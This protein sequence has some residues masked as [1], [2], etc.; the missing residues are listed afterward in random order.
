MKKIAMLILCFVSLFALVACNDSSS[1]SGYKDTIETPNDLPPLADLEYVQYP[2]KPSG[3][4]AGQGSGMP[5][6]GEATTTSEHYKINQA[7]GKI[8][9]TFNEVGKWDY[10]YIPL[11]NFNK[12]Y[13]NIN[14]DEPFALQLDK[15][16]TDIKRLIN[17]ED[18][19]LPSYS[20]FYSQRILI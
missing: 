14:F 4:S 9:I 12:E 19:I 8:T 18:I 13:Q 15:L 6:I 1:E 17:K 16:S 3:I 10:V 11:N 5:T 7:D 2:E 20:F